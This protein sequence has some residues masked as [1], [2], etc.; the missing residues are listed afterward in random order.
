MNGMHLAELNVGRLSAPTDDPRVAE[1]KL[2]L[3][4]V[5]RAARAFF[6]YDPLPLL[7]DGKCPHCGHSHGPRL[8]FFQCSACG[9]L[10]HDNE[11]G[12]RMSVLRWQDWLRVS[13]VTLVAIGGLIAL[14]L[15]IDR[16]FG[17][18]ISYLLNSWG[19]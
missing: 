2:G 18:E 6:L 17:D 4:R 16:T 11:M 13:I 15:W 5:A 9:E 10:V 3:D 8:G 14:C 19:L 7:N 12:R 1:F